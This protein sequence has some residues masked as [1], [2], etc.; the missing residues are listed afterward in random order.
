MNVDSLSVLSFSVK[1]GV[2]LAP[3]HVG[4]LGP[5]NP[6]NPP[7]DEVKAPSED[8]DAR[9]SPPSRCVSWNPRTALTSGGSAFVTAYRV[10]GRWSLGTETQ[11]EDGDEPNPGVGSPPP[12]VSPEGETESAVS[13]PVCLGHRVDALVIAWRVQLGADGRDALRRACASAA[14]NGKAQ[15]RLDTQTG[16]CLAQVRRHGGERVIFENADLRGCFVESLSGEDVGWSLEIT[17]RAVW[18]ATEQIEAVVEEMRIWAAAFG[19]IH[20]E[21]LRRI[22]LCADF[23]GW[24]LADADGRAF[25]K[26]SRSKM[27]S[28]TR[29]SKPDEV[30][31]KR[32][33][34]TYRIADKP[35]DIW[36]KTYRV[37]GDRV[38]GHTICPGNALMGRIYDKTEEL[39]VFAGNEEKR[40]IETLGWQ[41]QGWK[42]GQ[43]T[44][45]EFQLR[46]DALKELV[47]R[48]VDK[49]TSELASIWSYCTQQWL[50]M[51]L[52]G[53]ATRTRRAELDPRWD[54]AQTVDWGGTPKVLVRERKRN[55]ASV[56][57]GWGTLVTA[58]AKNGAISQDLLDQRAQLES[59]AM[60]SPAHAWAALAQ[61]VDDCTLAFS[62]LVHETVLAHHENDAPRALTA[63]FEKLFA[64][65]AR[66]TRNAEREAPHH[67]EATRLEQLLQGENE[68]LGS[69]DSLAV[70]LDRE[71][72]TVPMV[73]SPL[74]DG[75]SCMR[76]GKLAL[77][78]L[79][80]GYEI[81]S[82]LRRIVA[83]AN[84][85]SEQTKNAPD[86][87]RHEQTP[88]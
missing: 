45:V 51:V 9:P 1:Q 41:D 58:L 82:L 38:T 3:S 57:Q 43:V 48:S 34:K 19:A 86:T 37:A 17:A 59:V 75:G 56:Q 87:D 22:D 69:S 79:E 24:P 50:R 70:S 27:A 11:S 71:P 4:V 46:G 31:A 12:E 18:L 23:E 55:S 67:G 32:A 60:Q 20:E 6:W 73:S 52:P 40:R 14:E 49:A 61:V 8:S 42:G 64:A 21:R 29:G 65:V 84:R 74:R 54:A 15:L 88:T 36:G 28:Y 81:G 13:R 77:G 7:P 83:R 63:T 66:E 30:W 10:D 53:T 62:G 35:D 76:H 47:H 68:Q 44:R 25:V 26:R 39:R 2:G 80:P 16:A 33:G 85:R 78:E 72:T 5:G